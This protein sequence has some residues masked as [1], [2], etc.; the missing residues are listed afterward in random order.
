[1]FPFWAVST[2]LVSEVKGLEKIKQKLWLKAL[3]TD[4]EISIWTSNIDLGP[5]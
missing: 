3:T 1:V 4:F 5:N 2:D